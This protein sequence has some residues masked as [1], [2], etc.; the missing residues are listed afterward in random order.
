MDEIDVQK[1]AKLARLNLKKE[2]EA[3][4]K[5]KFKSILK[6]VGKIS[7]LEISDDMKEKDELDDVLMVSRWMKGVAVAYY[8]RY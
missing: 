3:Y 2:D 8:L 4:F 1:V 5:A 7:E 6:Y